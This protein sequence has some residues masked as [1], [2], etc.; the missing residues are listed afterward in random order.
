MV[1]KLFHDSKDNIEHAVQLLDNQIANLG[2]IPHVIH[3]GPIIRREGNY[4]SLSI[5][6][7]K[8]LLNALIHFSRRI[9]VKYAIDAMQRIQHIMKLKEHRV[10]IRQ[11]TRL[12]G[13]SRSIVERA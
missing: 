10:S 12:T 1:A 4:I 7:R 3:T 11:I 9:D 6:E 8:W 13:V 2:H 5:D